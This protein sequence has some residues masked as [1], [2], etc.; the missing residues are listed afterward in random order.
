M[1]TFKTILNNVKQTRSNLNNIFEC[2][3]KYDNV[4]KWLENTPKQR[5]QNTGKDSTGEK[6]KTDRSG[7]NEFYSDL[8]I[9]LKENESGI[10]SISEHVTLTQSGRFWQSLKIVFFESGFKYDADFVKEDGH[11]YRNFTRDYDSAE[12]FE[13]KIAGVS[14]EELSFMLKNMII[15][16]LIKELRATL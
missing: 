1:P 4:Q 7:L 16:T 12:D 5:I 14:V 3:F 8:T 6:L 2:V 15:P 11:M 10:G 13:K 9:I